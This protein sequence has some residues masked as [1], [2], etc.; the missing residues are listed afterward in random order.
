MNG[1]QLFEELT[2]LKLLNHDTVFILVTVENF[3][4][5][6]RAIIELKPDEYLLKPFN[7]ITLRESISAAVKRKSLLQAIYQA[8]L[9]N[10]AHAGLEACDELTPFHSEY[11]SL[12]KSF[13]P[14][15]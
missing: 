1:K 2:H 14:T 12:S 7:S 9:N 8:E 3:A 4:T 15:S 11:F 13:E 6:V 5:I 10:D